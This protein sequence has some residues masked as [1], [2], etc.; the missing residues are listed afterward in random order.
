VTVHVDQGTERSGARAVV[1]DDGSAIWLTTYGEEGA[2]VPVVLAPVR[3]IAIAGELIRAA[4]PK[5]SHGNER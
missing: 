3:A 1:S 4:L 5:I 2:A